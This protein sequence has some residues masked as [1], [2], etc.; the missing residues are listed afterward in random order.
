MLRTYFCN[1][2]AHLAVSPVASS[3]KSGAALIDF[4]ACDHLKNKK[5]GMLKANPLD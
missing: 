1:R 3:R 4:G 5:P 2:P